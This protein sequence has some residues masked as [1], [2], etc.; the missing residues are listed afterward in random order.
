MLE[1][2]DADIRAHLVDRRPFG[3]GR[4]AGCRERRARHVRACAEDARGVALH[5]RA[6]LGRAVDARAGL[7]GDVR[8]VVGMVT[9][10]VAEED[11]LGL[12]VDQL[13]QRRRNIAFGVRHAVDVRI[14]Q[15][16]ASSRRDGVRLH[17]EPGD[18]HLLLVDGPGL[19]VDVLNAEKVRARGHERGIG[20]GLRRHRVR[21][22][23]E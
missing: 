20:G 1:R 3:T 10:A 11:R 8:G 16:H 22:R 21:Q 13:L 5:R 4:R 9:M 14:E 15:E 23:K 2:R 7:H 19:R 18:D 12:Q 17:A 6:M